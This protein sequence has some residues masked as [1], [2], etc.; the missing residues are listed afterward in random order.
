MEA[1]GELAIV[2]AMY[3]VASGVVD[4]SVVPF[5]ATEAA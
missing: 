3:D 2:G 1:R 5:T 4:F